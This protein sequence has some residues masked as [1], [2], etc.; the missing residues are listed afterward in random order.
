MTNNAEMMTPVRVIDLRSDTVTRPS[1]A[2]RTAISLAEVGDDVYGEDPTVH[3]LERRAAELLGFEAALF[4]PTGTMAN[5]IAVMVHCR[6][7]DSE[8]ILGHRSHIHLY[9]QGGIAT[10]AGVHTRV[11]KN[12]ADGT[13]DLEEVEAAIRLDDV[14]FPVT[15]L[16]CVENTHNMCG[17]R[18][19]SPLFMTRLTQLAQS[20]GVAVHVDGARLLNAAVALGVPPD[21]LLVNCS[22]S[23]LCLSKSLGAP[24]GSMLAGSAAFIAQARRRRKVLGG[25]WRQAGVLA[26]AGLVALDAMIDRLVEDHQA[27]Q[28]VARTVSNVA[29]A[30]VQCDPEHVDTNIVM[31]TLTDDCGIQT[32]DICTALK[33]ATIKEMEAI[34]ESVSVIVSAIS[35]RCLRLVFHADISTDDVDL[36]IKKLTYVLQKIN[37][38]KK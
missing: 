1:Q 10:L 9:E 22:S 29:P 7:G 31:V 36:V 26:A 33:E 32:A 13:L 19:I 3:E 18:V 23:T 35:S 30:L 28:R 38:N 8:A 2:M 17:G 37:A 6:G 12:H 20:R 34:G 27:A 4:I 5:L 14:H 11:V 21:R 16:I 25:G 15:R 24:V